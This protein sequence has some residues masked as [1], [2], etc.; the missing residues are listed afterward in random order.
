MSY[1]R[2]HKDHGNIYRVESLVNFGGEQMV[3]HVVPAP[4]ADALKRD[5][6]EVTMS[7]VM[8]KGYNPV[9][10]VGNEVFNEANLY[11]SGPSFFDLFSFRLLAGDPEN[12]LGDPYS[13]VISESVAERFFGNTGP[14][15]KTILLDNKQL[16]TIT[17]ILEDTPSNS[18]LKIDYLV[19]FSILAEKGRNL[20]KWGNIDYIT[21]IKLADN[22][23]PEQFNRKIGSYLEDKNMFGTATLFINP[24]DRIHLYNDPGFENFSTGQNSRGPIKKVVFFGMTGILI[25]ILACINFIN[26]ATATA[27]GRAREIGVRKVAGAGRADLMLRLFGESLLQTLIATVIAFLFAVLLAPVFERISGIEISEGNIFNLKNI[28]ASLVL[29]LIT[30]LLA[31]TYPA[32]VLSSF[33]PVRVLRPSVNNSLDGSRL[34]K[35]LVIFQFVLTV[36]FVFSITV[37]SR[38]IHFMQNKKLGF[39]TEG[40]MVITLSRGT[41]DEANYDALM[42]ELRSIAAVEAVAMGGGIP[43][44]MGNFNIFSKW[45]GNDTGKSLKFHMLQVDDDYLDLLGLEI[46][47]GRPITRGIYNDEVV[48]NQTA[49]RQMDMEDPA[50]KVI[51][52]NGKTYTIVG[53]VKDFYFRKLNEEIKPVIIYKNP[54]WWMR[55]ILV[56]LS[57]GV[58]SD[59]IERISSVVKAF[60]PD[61]P[62]TFSFLDEEVK[63]YYRDERN[64]GMLMDAATIL[65]LVISCIGLF[66]LAAFTTRRRYRE[67]GLRKAHGATPAGLVALLS[68]EYVILVLISSVIALPAGYWLTGRWLAG[69]AERISIT[70]QFFILTILSVTCLSLLTVA[71]HTIRAAFL[72]PARTLREE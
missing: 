4:T 8:Q 39:D 63:D 43:V 72:D 33:S 29:M 67:I 65:S 7:V 23:N 71:F 3:W 40:I 64:V 52:G 35:T 61:F 49:A 5:F 42:S 51:A 38:Q 31:G 14:L 26:L 10:R 11:Y 20:E 6:Q 48:I 60:T 19:P 17:G 46:V 50:G 53:V 70:P 47:S 56:R 12:V 69:Y 44:N 66:G 15:G 32:L 45:T 68:R 27:T 22:V 25:L 2:F 18:H 41:G 54:E 13:V 1:D 36:I 34:R 28:T 58:Q 59:A 37:M 30:G 21:Y 55:R 62:V 24:L 9:L 16:L 57:P